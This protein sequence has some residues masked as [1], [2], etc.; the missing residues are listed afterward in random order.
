VNRRAFIALL[1]GVAAWPLVARAQ[2]PSMPVIG[3]LHQGSPQPSAHL[4]DAF[5]LGLREAGYVEGRNVVLEFRWANGEYD[6]LPALA[7]DLVRR[8]PSVIT[9]ALLPAARA[10]KA[11]TATIPIV[12]VTGSDPIESG[13]VTSFNRPAEN[14]T[15]VSLFSVVLAAKR[16]E[17]LHEFVPRATVFAVLVNPTNPNA[18]SNM[19]EIEAAAHRTGLQIAFIRISSDRD[20]DAVFSTISQLR[21]GALMVSA[22]GFFASQREQLIALA[23]RLAVPTIYFQREFVNAGGLISYGASSSDMY[24]HAGIYA[25]KILKG[26]KPTELP[27]EQPTKFEL[28]INLKTAKALGLDIPPMLLAR[29]DEVIE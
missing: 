25:G 3:F 5:R 9:A 19:R 24:R 12:F 21:A 18:A 26:A 27:I 16:L 14:V 22:D 1:G 28:V 20:Y 17:L 10:A 29:A 2:Q 6:Q 8:Q 7:A 11:A 13:L 15:G 23:A 4:I